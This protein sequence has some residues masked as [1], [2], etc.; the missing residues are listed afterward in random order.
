MPKDRPKAIGYYYGDHRTAD[1]IQST[2]DMR[3]G[4]FSR[5]QKDSIYD[6]TQDDMNGGYDK[7]TRQPDGGEKETTT[8]W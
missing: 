8:G 3:A 7:S 1:S 2:L 6:S 5:L 4:K